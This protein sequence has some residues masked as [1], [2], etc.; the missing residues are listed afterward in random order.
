MNPKDVKEIIDYLTGKG[1][2]VLESYI[3]WFITSSIIWI[4]FGILLI[5]LTK[6]ALT[7]INIE[8][9]IK[10]M[11]FYIVILIG[12]LFILTNAIDLISPTG[13]ATHQLL[14]DLRGH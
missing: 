14:K 2:I 3:T 9:L 7:K 13:I 11:I 12:L 1:S 10:D 4:F 5:V 6:L 8:P